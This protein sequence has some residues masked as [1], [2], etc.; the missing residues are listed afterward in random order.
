MINENMKLIENGYLLQLEMIRDTFK[1]D[2]IEEA[3]DILSGPNPDS[4]EVDRVVRQINFLGQEDLQEVDKIRKSTQRVSVS[5]QQTI[6]RTCKKIEMVMG[7]LQEHIRR[8]DFNRKDIHKE[9]EEACG[10]KGGDSH[11]DGSS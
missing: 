5:I 9:L 7:R 10:N 2:K 1:E 8:C 3:Y 11:D 4:K 6:H